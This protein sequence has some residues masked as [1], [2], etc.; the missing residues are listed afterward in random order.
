M[1]VG[2]TELPPEGM[3][4]GGVA[5]AGDADRGTKT[6]EGLS[7]LFTTAGITVQGPQPQIERLL[8]WSGLDT[9]TCRE[10]IALN[11]GR[12]AAVME[13][14]SGG[15]SIRFLLPTETVTPGQAA[16]LDQ[17]LPAWLARYKG[18]SA[19]NGAA[20]STPPA[21][22]ASSTS[23]SNAFQPAGAAA[24]GAAAAAAATGA[25]AYG[26]P[27]VPGA[28]S[29][30]AGSPQTPMAPAAT[31]QTAS[32]P[33]P[34]PGPTFTAAPA[35]APAGAPPPPPPPAA[36]P[37]PSEWAPAAA[38]ATGSAAWET[39]AGTGA[40]GPD[41]SGW[42]NPP[43]GQVAAADVLPPPKKTRS[44]RK[45]Q[46]EGETPAPGAGA[47]GSPPFDP[48]AIDLGTLP[49]PPAGYTLPNGGGAPVSWTPPVDPATGQTQWDNPASPTGVLAP[50]EAAPKK[51][52]GWRKG[53]KAT[54]AAAGAAAGVTGASALASP[55]DLT[56]PAPGAGTGMGTAM[57]SPSDP[58]FAAVPPAGPGDGFTP[59][60][61][62]EAPPPKSSR[63]TLL[64]V[65]LLIVVVVA[66]GVFYYFKKH[67]SSTPAVTTPTVTAPSGTAADIALAGSINLRLTDLPAGWARSP[68]TVQGAI[69]PVTPAASQVQAERVFAACVGQPLAVVAGMFGTA[70]LPGQ[71]AAVKSPT[72][73]SGANANIQM[74]STT[75][76]MGTAA[77][78]APLAAPFANANFLTCFTQYQSALIAA[79]V[80]GATAKV[81]P[82]TLPVPSGVKSYG[83]I[84]TFT[85][86]NQGT[87]V[88][89]E[90]FIL[91]GR[92]E[93]R[94]EP[95]TNGP[96]IPS[97]AFNPAYSAIVARVAQAA[98]K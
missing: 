61:T 13:L 67:S 66:A 71:T 29:T 44:W 93:T 34:P 88:V 87:E 8:V 15:Q 1:T 39:T 10:K 16:Y 40:P 94:L 78:A 38:G 82:V 95:T 33:P 64:L 85:V 80:P 20:A 46:A 31:A 75:T 47:P 6:T 2:I 35:A 83:Y 81:Q 23:D 92:T 97:S 52:R 43:L 7:L 12:S 11:D 54:A 14:T 36:S 84:T 50:E 17:A 49:P 56:P 73:E 77:E 18:T 55:G 69:P 96:A 4:L 62:T 28:P 42:D 74:Y 45:G 25:A 91:G 3:Q 79:S 58:F 65:I 90:G 60:T 86:P 63:S 51:S 76:V 89:G 37:A 98:N 24:A 30:P 26:A 68:T 22:S 32:P 27:P 41:A 70:A 5:L 9:A 72:F 19:P 53:S 48:A 59:P 21:A 57:P